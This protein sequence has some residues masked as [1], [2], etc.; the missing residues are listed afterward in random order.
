M[1]NMTVKPVRVVIG[2]YRQPVIYDSVNHTLRL[3]NGTIVPLSGNADTAHVTVDPLAY[4]ILA[5]N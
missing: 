3:P 2:G 4:Y 1:I 5:S